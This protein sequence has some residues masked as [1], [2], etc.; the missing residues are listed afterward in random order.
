[1]NGV[2]PPL[3]ILNFPS[4]SVLPNGALYTVP[5]DSDKL[6]RMQGMNQSVVYKRQV[7]GWRLGR[8][9]NRSLKLGTSRSVMAREKHQENFHFYTRGVEVHLLLKT[10][11][12]YGNCQQ[13]QYVI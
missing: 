1:M 8:V 12:K 3:G 4:P 10:V 13:Q 5:L 9:T 11:L 7:P 2:N 6:Q